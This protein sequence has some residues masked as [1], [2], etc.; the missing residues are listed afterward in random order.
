MNNEYILCIRF[1]EKYHRGEVGEKEQKVIKGCMPMVW[2]GT[3]Y[4][5]QLPRFPI[6]GESI[7]FTDGIPLEGCEVEIYND[8]NDY[9][10]ENIEWQFGEDKNQ[11]YLHV[12]AKDWWLI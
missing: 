12:I 7:A 5:A 6:A 1:T 3:D 9:Y 8:M 4:F 2:L 11:V 10:I